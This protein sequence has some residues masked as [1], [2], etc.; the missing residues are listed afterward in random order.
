MEVVITHRFYSVIMMGALMELFV[1][2]TATRLAMLDYMLFI[3]LV[4]LFVTLLVCTQN[5]I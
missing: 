3:Q 5:S 4:D 1:I 2:T